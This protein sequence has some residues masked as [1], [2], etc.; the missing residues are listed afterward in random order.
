MTTNSDMDETNRRTQIVNIIASNKSPMGKLEAIDEV[1]NKEKLALLDRLEK[2]AERIWYEG[3]DDATW[4]DTVVR[5]SVIKQ[6]RNSIIKDKT[7]V[8]DE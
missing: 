3:G 6:E 4:A 2:Q 1:I 5:L 8:S 7:G